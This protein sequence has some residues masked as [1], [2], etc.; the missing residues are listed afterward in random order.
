MS[1]KVSSESPPQP[2]SVMT[3]E[4]RSAVR[5]TVWEAL[6]N[7]AIRALGIDTMCRSLHA[8]RC[9][10][11]GVPFVSIGSGYGLVEYIAEETVPDDVNGGTMEWIG[12]DPDPGSWPRRDLRGEDGPFFPATYRDAETLARQ[13]PDMV[14]NCVVVL[15]WPSPNDSTYD[16]DAVGILEPLAV[17]ATVERFLR[18]NGA[19]GGFLFHCFA[20]GFPAD[21]EEADVNQGWQTQ[22]V[23]RKIRAL[24]ERYIF[25]QEIQSYTSGPQRPSGLPPAFDFFGLGSSIF[26]PSSNSIDVRLHIQV[27]SD[28]HNGMHG[29]DVANAVRKEHECLT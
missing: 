16:I 2:K 14:G 8:M 22:S 28:G 3:S 29:V 19:A 13:R 15:N 23:P 9:I 18:G 5:E 27:R 11:P 25:A 7:Q 24:R 10:F 26:G 21:G 4:W 12:V 17:W 20:F 6:E 1:A